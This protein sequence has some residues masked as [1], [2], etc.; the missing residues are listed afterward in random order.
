MGIATAFP[1]QEAE[2]LQAIYI[3]GRCDCLWVSAVSD[4]L[5]QI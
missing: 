4:G 1:D 5:T 3:M 2:Y